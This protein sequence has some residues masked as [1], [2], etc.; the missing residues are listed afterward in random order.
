MTLL[1]EAEVAQ[2]LRIH[3][4]TLKRWRE[5]RGLPHLRLGPTSHSAVRYDPEAV[6]AWLRAQMHGKVPAPLP[7]A[8]VRRRPGRPR[9][10]VPW[11]GGGTR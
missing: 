11:G 5:E 9:G 4:R 3:V 2:L 8:P 6:D 10:T 1:T 7:P